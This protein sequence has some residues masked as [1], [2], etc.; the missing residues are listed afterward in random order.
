MGFQQDLVM[1]SL[2]FFEQCVMLFLQKWWTVSGTFRSWAD[3]L[4]D[5]SSTQ[6]SPAGFQS[7]W[8]FVVEMRPPDS[9][10]GWRAPRPHQV[11]ADAVQE[12][13]ACVEGTQATSL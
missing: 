5:G 11:F 9:R 6:D 1:V 10:D 4:A 2:T 7:C 3:A 8:I 12:L 13:D